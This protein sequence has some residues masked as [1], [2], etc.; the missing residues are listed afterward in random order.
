MFLYS[1]LDVASE[2]IA[3]LEEIIGNYDTFIYTY[4]EIMEY[5]NKTYEWWIGKTHVKY[6]RVGCLCGRGD[7]IRD[8]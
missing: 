7:G 4:E 8:G 3:N 2:S 6:T 1:A 5:V